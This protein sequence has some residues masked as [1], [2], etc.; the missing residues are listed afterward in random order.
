MTTKRRNQY[1][2]RKA[3]LS[4]VAPLAICAFVIASTA[5]AQTAPAVSAAQGQTSA[6][7]STAQA[8]SPASS[9]SQ[10]MPKDNAPKLKF[11]PKLPFDVTKL[12]PGVPVAFNL[13]SGQPANAPA[14]DAE[15]MKMDTALTP[16]GE[17]NTPTTVSGGNPPY[18]FQLDSGSFPP[19]GM[20]LG[21]NGL[22]YGTPAPPTLGG[23]KPFRVCAV[24]LS[25]TADCH[26]VGGAP[27]S[28][29]PVKSAHTGAIVLGTVAAVG[30]VGAV[31]AAK[32]ADSTSSTSS[33]SSNNC[34]ALTNS[35]NNLA[36]ECLN[37]NDASACQQIPSVCTQMCQ[38]D[39]FSSFNTET[40]SCQ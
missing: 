3:L 30:V 23:Y 7:T 32:M 2:H 8:T 1:Q 35:C 34:T 39:G 25:A 17:Q 20:H 40:G 24:D 16:C 5:V 10:A 11:N 29:Q 31:A 27:T 33:S 13:C 6:S 9:S 28:A 18:S 26:E 15:G 12:Q 38:C 14:N 4:I 36:A 22:L 37:D 19:L 21:L